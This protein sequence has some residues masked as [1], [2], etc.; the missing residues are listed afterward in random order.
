[1]ILRRLLIVFCIFAFLL[2]LFFALWNPEWSNGDEPHYLTVSSSIAR[3]RDFNV[4]NN[5]NNFDYFPHHGE[6]IDK[7]KFNGVD[8]SYRPFHGILLSVLVAPGLYAQ[9]L[10]GARVNMWVLCLAGFYLLFVVL[11]KLGISANQ[12][13][14]TLGLIGIQP[15]VIYHASAIFPD[16]LQG[17]IMLGTGFLLY[18]YISEK[19]KWLLVLSGSI[20]GLSLFLHSKLIVFCVLQIIAFSLVGFLK[21]NKSES[22][23]VFFSQ[24]S[25]TTLYVLVPFITGILSL[26]WLN[27]RWFG[28]FRP[29]IFS[30]F[31][32]NVSPYNEIHNPFINSMAMLY[33]S[34][35][36]LV[37]YGVLFIILLPSMFL[38]F[39]KQRESFLLLALPGLIFLFILGLFKDWPGGWCP[40]ARYVM[41]VLPVLLPG[42]GFVIQKYI[43]FTWAKLLTLG[44][45]GISV[46]SFLFIV[47]FRIVG[48]TRDL[49]NPLIGTFLRKLN[50]SS[51]TDNIDLNFFFPDT[52]FYPKLFGIVICTIVLGILMMKEKTP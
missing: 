17:F 15:V 48:Y 50:L 22:I 8:G 11:R 29:D 23:K 10:I 9:Q 3:D 45:V 52:F 27:Y 34:D 25:R 21:R 2:Q 36:G 4:T 28:I 51:F 39:K 33:D 32:K 7:H 41:D 26:S 24:F 47:K 30:Y 16:L 13:L 5:Y 37:G 44:V 14:L 42:I 20:M 40:P 31:F 1:M 35:R 19:T 43:R 38:W 6:E 46:V 49:V 18:R 12:S